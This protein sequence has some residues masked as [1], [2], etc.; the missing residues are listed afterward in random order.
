MIECNSQCL[1]SKT[2]SN[3]L[4]QNGINLDIEVFPTPGKGWG[5]KTLQDI[6]KGQFVCEYAGEIISSKEAKRRTNLNQENHNYIIVIKEHIKNNQILSTHV[7]PM[8]FGNVGRFINHS[9]DPLLTMVPVRIDSLIP[10][11]A[12]F[13]AKNICKNTELTFDYSGGS[14]SGEEVSGPTPESSRKQCMCGTSSC[15]GYLPFD[16]SLFKST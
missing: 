7:D 12:L 11:L 10:V 2:C 3:R 16:S 5:L 4:V 14:C 8:Y 6:I 9:C 1:C 15:S 13:A